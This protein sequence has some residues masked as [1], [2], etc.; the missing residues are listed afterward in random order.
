MKFNI[1]LISFITVLLLSG[2]VY[3]QCDTIATL[4]ET[5]MSADFISDGQQYR[6]LL[7]SEEIAEFDVTLYGGSTYRLSACSGLSD[8]NLVFTILDQERNILFSNNEY[9]M[10]PY[11]DFSVTHTLDAIIEARLKPSEAESGCAVLLISFKP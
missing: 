8:G 3:S 6:A 10:S 11:W 2:S 4:C 1:R 9:G 7:R 5:H